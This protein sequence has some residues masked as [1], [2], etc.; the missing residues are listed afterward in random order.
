MRI[1]FEKGKQRELILR[2]KEKSG[3]TWDEFSKHL[4]I[5]SGK[6]HAYRYEE[7]LLTLELFEKFFFKEDYRKKVL[8][9]REDNWGRSNGGKLSKGSTKEIK[10][11]SDSSE[12]AE[13]Y[14]I[15]LGDGNLTRIKS[16]KVGTYEARIVGDSRNDKDYLL[17]YVRPLIEKLFKIEVA[18]FKFKKQNAIALVI[19]GRNL[20]DFLESKGFKPGDKIR[21]NLRIPGWIKENDSFL[22]ACLRGLFDT[23]GT[24]YKLTNQ[25]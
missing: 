20:V 12:L 16:Y 11:P 19:H 24:A 25:N 22:K 8:E 21:N 3:L 4:N 18:I 13:F 2:E 10:T 1:V 15:M 7:A 17:D 5:K 9:T 23:D 6:L 14:G